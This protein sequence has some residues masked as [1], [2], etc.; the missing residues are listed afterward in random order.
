VVQKE[1]NGCQDFREIR[2][3]LNG[4]NLRIYANPSTDTGIMGIYK[5]L[6]EGA[7]HKVFTIHINKMPVN[8]DGRPNQFFIGLIDPVSSKLSG[9]YLEISTGAGNDFLTRKF[10]GKYL[11]QSIFKNSVIILDC[12]IDESRKTI[13]NLVI[14]GVPVSFED[15]PGSENIKAFFIGYSVN[16]G[17]TLDI[18]IEDNNDEPFFR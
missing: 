1:T 6:P 7:W 14:D 15:I 13:C 8:S 5:L 11:K 16:K 12:S 4:R 2:T 17:G 18:V 9:A 10:A 3:T